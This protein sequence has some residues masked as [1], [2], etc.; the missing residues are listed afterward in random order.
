MFV[1]DPVKQQQQQQQPTCLMSLAMLGSSAF[2]GVI[3]LMSATLGHSQDLRPTSLFGDNMVLQRN[4]LCP[5]F[6][7][8]VP[9]AVEMLYG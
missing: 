4:A 8:A 2:V 5:I 9:G 7:Y 1:V 3:V 6:G